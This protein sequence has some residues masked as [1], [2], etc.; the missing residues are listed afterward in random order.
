MILTPNTIEQMRRY[1]H[2]DETLEQMLLQQLGTEPYPHT[3][4]EQDI[5]EQSRKMIVGY[6]QSRA[7][8]ENGIERSMANIPN[9][10]E[11]RRRNPVKPYK[12][13]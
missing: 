12:T 11:I 3:Y 10:E 5:H 6:N 7:A 4:T 2:I 1:W 8:T 13:T 9:H